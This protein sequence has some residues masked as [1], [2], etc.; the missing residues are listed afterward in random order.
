MGKVTCESWSRQNQ[1]R[2]EALAADT[3]DVERP[4]SA[5]N[6]E[7][8][9]IKHSSQNV[10]IKVH[11]KEGKREEGREERREEGRR[12]GRRAGKTEGKPHRSEMNRKAA[13]GS[14]AVWS[15]DQR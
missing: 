13:R 1:Y 8:N 12:G 3:A 10:K 6:S 2:C 5:V 4:I 9:L 15:M 14:T 11:V 7:K